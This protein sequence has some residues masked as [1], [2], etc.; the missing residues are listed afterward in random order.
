MPSLPCPATGADSSPAP[1][2]LTH[3]ERLPERPGSQATDCHTLEPT[4]CH[5]A[6]PCCFP[7]AV[8]ASQSIATGNVQLRKAVRTNQGTRKYLLTFLLVASLGLLFLDWWSS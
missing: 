8:D 7:Q 4:P 5:P 1:L 2:L 3:P 6:P